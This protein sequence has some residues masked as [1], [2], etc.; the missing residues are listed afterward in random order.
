LDSLHGVRNARRRWRV[1]K[2][3]SKASPPC[4]LRPIIRPGLCSGQEDGR[5]E[6]LGGRSIGT[7]RS[8]TE[9]AGARCMRREQHKSP[10]RTAPT[11]RE[12]NRMLLACPAPGDL[13]TNTTNFR[14]CQGKVLTF[15][16][17]RPMSH[18]LRFSISWGSRCQ[19]PDGD[20]LVIGKPSPPGF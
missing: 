10:H 11:L 17:L 7:G 16:T 8:D 6:A 5:R 19:Y 4:N 9:P 13:L 20:R 15:E 2:L 18:T 1:D 14:C 12:Q 3:C